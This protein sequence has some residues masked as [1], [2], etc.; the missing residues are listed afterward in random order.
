MLNINR[1]WCYYLS[2]LLFILWVCRGE[3]SWWHCFFD[4]IF[5]LLFSRN[6]AVHMFG[7]WCAF[8]SS[9]SFLASS[10]S[11]VYFFFSLSWMVLLSH[12]MTSH[13]TPFLFCF[14]DHYFLNLY[15]IS[16][17]LELFQTKYI[18]FFSFIFYFWQHFLFELSNKKL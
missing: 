13:P 3:M 9:P 7:I 12:F 2:D 17:A 14:N 16:Q 6:S 8:V 15:R 11:N 1:C 4:R 18:A 5:F 10:Y